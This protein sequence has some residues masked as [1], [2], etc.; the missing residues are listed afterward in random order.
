VADLRDMCV[1][2][3]HRLEEGADCVLCARSA[4]CSQKQLVFSFQGRNRIWNLC[5]LL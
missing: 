5:L 2:V 1:W 3:V 4:G